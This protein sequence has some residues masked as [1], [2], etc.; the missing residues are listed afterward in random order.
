MFYKLTQQ[1]EVTKKNKIKLIK[2][3]EQKD[4]FLV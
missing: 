3:K 1:I 4:V 2:S